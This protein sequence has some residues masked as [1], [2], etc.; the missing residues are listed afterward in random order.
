MHENRFHMDPAAGRRLPLSRTPSGPR[1][2]AGLG[3][4]LPIAQKRDGATACP[5]AEA[6][7]DGE[8]HGRSHHGRHRIVV[9][10]AG[11]GGLE[12]VHRLAG[13][14]VAITLVDRR[15]HHLF[16]PLLYQVATASLATSE[17]AWPT[18]HALARRDD[19]TTLL[20]TVTGIDTAARPRPARRRRHP[21]IRHADPRHRRPPRLFRP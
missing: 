3:D 8:R 15:N 20:A 19:V 21:A 14:P 11:F 13:A 18:R 2:P 7:I 16:Q 10:G 6:G 17:I 1:S 9:V 12:A 5:A 4:R